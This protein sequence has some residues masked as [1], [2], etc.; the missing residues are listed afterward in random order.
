[1]TRRSSRDSTVLQVWKL[2]TAWEIL[3]FNFQLSFHQYGAHFYRDN[4]RMILRLNVTEDY[5]PIASMA[6]QSQ[7][8]L[9]TSS[10]MRNKKQCVVGTD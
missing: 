8:D 10:K 6:N 1:M 2:K 5:V 4:L 3:H 9:P 7:T